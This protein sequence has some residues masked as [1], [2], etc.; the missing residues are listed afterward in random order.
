MIERLKIKNYALLK[1][2][3]IDFKKGLTIIS[4]ETGSGKSILLDAL[5][6]LLGKRVERLFIK[7]NSSKTIIEGL[8]RI[9]S[10]MMFF[11]EKHKLDF[12]EKTILRRELN[13]DGRSRAFINDT[14]VL[15]SV[16]SDFG[17][18]IV[19]INAQNQSLLLKDEA[20]QFFVIDKLAESEKY[21]LD[22]QKEFEKYNQLVSELE[23]IKK[24]GSISDTELD[25]LR[26]Q[27]EEI[28][29]SALKIGENNE[30]IAQ[31][32][33]LENV[34]ILIDSLSSS[35]EILN[36]EQGILTQLSSIKRKLSNSDS[37][38]D[39]FNRIDSV[40]IELNDVS[41]DLSSMSNVLKPDPERL[42][43]LNARLDLI[44][45]LLL[46]HKKNSIEDLI[47]YQKELQNKID[48]SKSF[49][50]NLLKKRKEIE[51]QYLNLEKSAVRLNN[52]R[53]KIL[54]SFKK[55]VED[56]LLNLGMPHAKFMATLNESAHF[57][58]FG[59]KT[60]SFLFSANKGSSLLEI[61]KVASGG[62]LSR[63][64][65]VVKYI[66][67]KISQVETLIFDEID[68]GVSGQ[69][70]SLMG[71][72]MLEMSKSN[73]LI[74]ISHLPQIAA[75]ANEHLKVV[76][77]VVGDKT[78]SDII[79]LNNKERVNEIAKLLSGKEVTSAA[80]EN[81]RVLLNQ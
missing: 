62:E 49:E 12:D 70:A 67:S 46:K 23:L 33:I 59:N 53:K 26:Y 37:F 77:S 6:L 25:F 79:I 17:N 68:V 72:M 5:T 60:V 31:I 22:Y 3:S 69:V 28:E 29:S 1:D 56:H 43:D 21:L 4:G 47:N 76:K 15:L 55:D 39:L 13:P 74:A 8:F 66:V 32:S 11:F 81:A 30:M 61:S 44:N 57:H 71:T 20:S 63:L 14:P 2:V 65:L 80:V 45:K 34:E 54:F 16:L 10:S 78:N 19:D 73:Q 75:K 35:E 24:S 48:L 64:M 27:F 58:K 51:R 7:S 52:K 18:H 38:A 41:N 42:I 36:S 40:I 50:S 9:K